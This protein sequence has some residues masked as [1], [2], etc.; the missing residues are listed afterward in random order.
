MI[1]G[2]ERSKPKQSVAAAYAN[3][4]C[5]PTPILQNFQFQDDCRGLSLLFFR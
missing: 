4:E 1:K 2:P 5:R 3:A